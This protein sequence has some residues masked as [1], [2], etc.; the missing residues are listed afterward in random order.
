[1]QLFYAAHKVYDRIRP[2]SREGSTTQDEVKDK[3]SRGEGVHLFTEV[4]ASPKEVA[5]ASRALDGFR[6]NLTSTTGCT[7]QS[8][9]VNTIMSLA[10]PGEK[11]RSRRLP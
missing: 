2:H 8:Q 3:L 11:R 1:M 4:D 6:A 5:D 9:E 7:E 10:T